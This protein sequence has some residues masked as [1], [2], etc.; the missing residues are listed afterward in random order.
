VALLLG[1]L[2][3]QAEGCNLGAAEG[4]ARDQVLVDR[5]GILAG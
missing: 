3:G 5:Q 2:L 1:L 4:D